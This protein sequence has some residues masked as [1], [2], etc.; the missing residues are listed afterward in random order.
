MLKKHIAAHSRQPLRFG[1]QEGSHVSYIRENIVPDVSE[2]NTR[3]KGKRNVAEEP[4]N[5][6]LCA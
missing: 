6:V 4:R 2:S 1:I 5:N 3:D